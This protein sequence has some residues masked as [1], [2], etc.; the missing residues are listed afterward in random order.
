MDINEYLK[1]NPDFKLL[2]SS[3]K[4]L[5][6]KD[7]IYLFCCPYTLP[8]FFLDFNDEVYIRPYPKVGR[9][10]NY[11]E[12]FSETIWYYLYDCPDDIFD[13]RYD[14]STDSDDD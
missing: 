1:D 11:Y 7:G 14:V 6:D 10:L 2:E 8:E 4:V 9:N 12:W 3:F 13:G 5:S